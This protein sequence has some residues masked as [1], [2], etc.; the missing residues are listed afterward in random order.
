[1]IAHVCVCVGGVCVCMCVYVYT[2][3]CACVCVILE[4]KNGE[5]RITLNIPLTRDRGTA[6]LAVTPTLICLLGN[7]HHVITAGLCRAH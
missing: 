3:E 4:L 1:M 7:L 5:S 2:C 6:A